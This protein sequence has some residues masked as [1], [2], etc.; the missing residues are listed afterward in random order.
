[1]DKTKMRI[2]AHMSSQTGDTLHVAGAMILDSQ[3][4]VIVVHAGE[5]WTN[6]GLL[7]FYRQV[8]D[9][10]YP[11]ADVEPDIAY[12]N[13]R[14]KAVYASNKEV[15]RLLYQALS[16]KGTL[17]R[18]SLLVIWPTTRRTSERHS[19]PPWNRL[20]ISVISRYSDVLSRD[21]PLTV[22]DAVPTIPK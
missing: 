17:T 11:G 3:I 10:G 6:K 2:L 18:Y 1:M 7:N 5:P 12:T 16:V 14:V 4:H 8:T 22:A 13:Q 19:L 9:P 15:A 21:R 20:E